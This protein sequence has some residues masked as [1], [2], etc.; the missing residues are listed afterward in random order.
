M[1]VYFVLGFAFGITLTKPLIG[2]G[3]TVMLVCAERPCRDVVVRIPAALTALRSQL[4]LTRPSFLR[5]NNRDGSL[6]RARMLSYRR[7]CRHSPR[8]AF[9]HLSQS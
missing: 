9:E 2:G 5:Y 8:R 4:I 1:A 3:V 6:V 7:G